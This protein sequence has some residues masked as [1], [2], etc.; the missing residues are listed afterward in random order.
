MRKAL[1]ALY[2]FMEQP[3]FLWSRPI[4][5]LSCL[6]LVATFFAPLWRIE[7]TAPQYRNGLSIDIYAH[8]IVGGH[9]GAD[10]A[11]INVLNHYIGM[12]KLD[13]KELSDLDWIPF[14]LGAL[15]LLTLRVASV[16]NVRASLELMV[17]TVY[18][19]T[20]SM[21][22]FVYRFYV[23]VH[24]LSPDA[25]IKVEGFTPAIIGTKQIANFSTSS[26]PALGTAAVAGFALCVTAVTVWHLWAGKRAA[27]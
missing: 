14:A 20:C 25:P 9:D 11:E 16:G 3:L 22:R 17:V 10:I 8:T 2:H 19:A 13:R 6:L 12:H 23:F 7:M 1:D 26:M 18:F 27:R 21:A 15:A 24:K 5:A 4:L